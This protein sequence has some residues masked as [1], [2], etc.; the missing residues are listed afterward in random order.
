[1]KKRLLIVLLR[2]VQAFILVGGLG[3]ILGILWANQFIPTC[4]LDRARVAAAEA[5]IKSLSCALSVYE[6]D[7]DAYPTTEQGLAALIAKPVDLGALRWKGPYLN[8]GE[9]PKDPWEH[10]YVYQG[11]PSGKTFRVFSA[12]PDGVVGTEDDIE[13]P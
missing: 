3:L 11:S 13:K 2:G 5:D 10:E 7:H 6:V 4:D 1:M 9:I 12:G 8:V